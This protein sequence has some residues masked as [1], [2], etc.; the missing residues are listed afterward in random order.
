MTD[1][2]DKKKKLKQGFT[3]YITKLRVPLPKESQFALDL[4]SINEEPVA[5]PN[6]HSIYYK[7][8]KYTE[9]YLWNA[10][11]KFNKDRQEWI[12]EAKKTTLIK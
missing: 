5:D 6:N 4:V 12:D 8:Y 11:A 9:K 7:A 10:Q 2:S 1:D 3:K